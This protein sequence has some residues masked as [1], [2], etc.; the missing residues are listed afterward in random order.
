MSVKDIFFSDQIIF[1]AIRGGD[2]SSDIA[3]DDVVLSNSACSEGVS[4]LHSFY[5]LILLS[6]TMMCRGSIL[7][8]DVT[9]ALH[10]HLGI[11]GSNPGCDRH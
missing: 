3:L 4:I 9:F 6:S 7:I 8:V 10:V 1:E 5:I 11:R 2:W